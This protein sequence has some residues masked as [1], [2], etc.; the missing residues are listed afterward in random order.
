VDEDEVVALIAEQLGV[1]LGVGQIGI[2]LRLTQAALRSLKGVVHG[3]GG[4]EEVAVA[5]D[6]L[7][8]GHQ[9]EVVLQRH[10]RSQ[11]LGDAAAVGGRVEMEDAGATQALG[12][13]LDR[14]QRRFGGLRLDTR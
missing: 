2:A 12:A 6:H 7:P 11:E 13:A 9:A 10:D 14:G 5:A 8:L 4:A 1:S 3:L